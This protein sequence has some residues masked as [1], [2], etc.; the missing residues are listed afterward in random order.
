M[1][2][3]ADLLSSKLMPWIL[4]APALPLVSMIFKG[5]RFSGLMVSILATCLLSMLTNMFFSVVSSN[6]NSVRNEIQLMGIT[7]ES[8]CSLVMIGLLN[9]DK[10]TRRILQSLVIATVAG[11]TIFMVFQSDFTE[12]RA[13]AAISYFIIF[14]MS[15]FTVYRLAAGNNEHFITDAPAFWIGGGQFMHYGL[16]TLLLSFIPNILPE[17]WPG[18]QGFGIMYTI[19]TC[20]R[21]ITLTIAVMSTQKQERW[22]GGY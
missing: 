9:R 20:I 18:Y 8:V 13:A 10:L 7:C 6:S 19:S 12:L 22:Q 21:F 4:M 2:L 14:V 3:P 5:T 1:L 15:G 17:H 11:L 16:M